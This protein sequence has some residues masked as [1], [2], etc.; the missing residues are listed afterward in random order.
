VDKFREYYFLIKTLQAFKGARD[1]CENSKNN[2]YKRYGGRGIKFLLT[3]EQIREIFKRDNALNL[4]KPS[5]DRINA[6]GD[7]SMDNCRFIEN[8]A[9]ALRAIV[10][11]V[12][13][14][15]L[16]Y[17]FIKRY[18]SITEAARAIGVEPKEISLCCNLETEKVDGYYWE[19]ENP[20]DAIGG[21]DV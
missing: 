21:E 10:K 12:I 2:A 19:F 11:P 15:D 3:L 7:Y 14:Y 17:N 13:Q 9:N 1:R 4:S 20:E 6:D 16:G 8:T 5:L 18:D